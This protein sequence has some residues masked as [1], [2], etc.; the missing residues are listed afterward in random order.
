MCFIT[1]YNLFSRVYKNFLLFCILMGVLE[2]CY[3]DSKLNSKF[4]NGNESVYYRNV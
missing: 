2:A 3:H 1:L 4:S